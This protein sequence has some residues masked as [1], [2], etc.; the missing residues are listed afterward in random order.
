MTPAAEEEK[1]CWESIVSV[2]KVIRK[3]YF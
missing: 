1:K 3:V 2:E